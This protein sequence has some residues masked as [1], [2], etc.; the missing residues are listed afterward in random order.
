MWLSYSVS[1][2]LYLL[3]FPPISSSPPPNIPSPGKQLFV[4]NL[5]TID[6]GEGEKKRESSYTVGEN[7]NFIATIEKNMEIPLKTKNRTAIQFSSPTSGHISGENNNLKRYMHTY[8]HCST[9][10][11]SQGM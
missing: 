7:V 5:Q 11:N 10:Y 2:S 3:I 4:Q 8:V 6:A 1:S 9:I